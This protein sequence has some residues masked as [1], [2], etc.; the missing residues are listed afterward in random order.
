VQDQLIAEYVTRMDA[1]RSAAG[2]FHD[3]VLMTIRYAFWHFK[4]Q[5]EYRRISLWSYLEGQ[6]RNSELEQRFTAA[7]IATMRAGQQAGLV[8]TDI[9]PFLMPFIIRG[10]IEYWIRKEHLVRR[11]AAVAAEAE[12]G[13]DERMVEALAVLFMK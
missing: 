8:R 11:M 10:A 12:A 2:D 13:A 4:G 6:E 1:T 9:D 7:L 3:L 5:E